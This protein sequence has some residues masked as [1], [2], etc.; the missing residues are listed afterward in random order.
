MLSTAFCP[1]CNA[2]HHTA[3]AST[4]TDTFFCCS[5]SR[6]SSTIPD[7]LLPY[8]SSHRKTF[9][10]RTR[11][12]WRH[13]GLR[14][15]TIVFKV[16]R[17]DT[18]KSSAGG[19]LLLWSLL[20]LFGVTWRYRTLHRYITASIAELCQHSLMLSSIDDYDPLD[21]KFSCESDEQKVACS[22]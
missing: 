8:L 5:R 2:R 22:T 6:F 3:T 9:I 4:L 16:F 20:F 21:G 10:D 7:R 17:S 11:R 19:L 14:I 12:A 13:R 18:S 1:T 15:E